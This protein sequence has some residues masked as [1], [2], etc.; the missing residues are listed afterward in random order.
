MILQR[1]LLQNFRSYNSADFRFH[2]GVNFIVGPN[3]SGKSNLIEAIY[4]CSLGKSYRTEQ[5]EQLV[6][7]S[8]DIGRVKASISKNGD[9]KIR[10][11]VTL[12]QGSVAGKTSFIKKYL[13]NDIAKRRADF[14]G[15]LPVLLFE[16]SDLDLVSGS[17]GLR[18][19]FLD[20]VLEQTDRDYRQNLL[21]FTK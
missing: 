8:Q 20:E 19:E 7:L 14:A 11:E 18:R 3:T 12:A 5:D 10:L 6:S 21:T 17:P 16:P 2:E 15:I 1:I 9:E 13:V 4:L